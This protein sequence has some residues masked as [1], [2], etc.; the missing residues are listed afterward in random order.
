MRSGPQRRGI[1]FFVNSLITQE[2]EMQK[3][4][5]K[6]SPPPNATSS[7]FYA[8]M[9]DILL[10]PAPDNGSWHNMP[11]SY[12]T[13]VDTALVTWILSANRNGHVLRLW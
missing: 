9:A 12:F 10:V 7:F 13:L 3:Q 1:L 5:E 6:C 4:V 11:C 8:C 2:L